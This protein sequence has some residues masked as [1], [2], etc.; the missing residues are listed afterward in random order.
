[1][2]FDEISGS[3]TVSELRNFINDSWV[4]PDRVLPTQLCD[5][6]TGEVLGPQAGSGSGQIETALAAA[7]LAWQRGDWCFCEPAQRAA[8]LEQVAALLEKR[9]EDIARA[10]ALQTGV[11]ISLTGK[12]AELCAAA[13][14]S[15][16]ALLREPVSTVP[17][18]GPHGELLLQRLPLGVAAIIAPW[19]APSGIACHKLA[20]ALAAGCPTIMKPSEWAP[21]SAQVIAEAVAAA[22]LPPGVFQMLHGDSD[23]GALLVVD[24][25][26]AAVSFTGGL[27]GGRAVARACAQ[28]MKPAQLELGGNNP[29]LVL[30]DAN[31]EAAADGVVTALTTLNGQWCRAL[32]RLLVHEAVA[33]PLLELVAQKLGRVKIGS[34][35]SH[36]SQMGPLVHSGHREHVLEALH[37]YQSMGAELLRCGELPALDGWFMQPTLVTGLKPEL[38]LEEIFG[39]VAVVHSFSSDEEAVALANQ[40]PCG[41][42][43]YVFGE[44]EH[45]WSVARGI[46]TGITKING[47]T[48]LN[49]N[50]SAPRPAWGLSGCGDEGSRETFEF[51]RGARLIGV[52]ARP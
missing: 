52:A 3:V 17:L 25:K 29:L 43:A 45:A 37:R 28:G 30:E 35:L 41:L 33:M 27:H 19:N 22:G 21:A 14:R 31:L 23:T 16:A 1:M 9:A 38:T 26:V 42:A 24:D 10:D 49:L 34:S 11:V 51:F 48:L 4:T 5:A 46:V 44:E 39:P 20:S 13:F 15:A 6:N 2:G 12:L 50:P 18:A 40:T 32:G 8:K 7:E 36:D 47:V